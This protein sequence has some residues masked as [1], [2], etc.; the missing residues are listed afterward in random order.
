[1]NNKRTH[2]IVAICLGLGLLTSLPAR[3]AAA[4]Q[5]LVKTDK[6][7]L[8]TDGRIGG[9]A[10]FAVGDAYPKSTALNTPYGGGVGTNDATSIDNTPPDTPLPQAKLRS[11]RIRSGFLSNIFAFGAR[12]QISDMK[13]TSY[14]QFWSDIES[15]GSRKYVP[16]PVDVRQ[17]FLKLEGRWGSLA[18]G[19]MGT[20]FSRGAAEIDFLYGH[21]YGVGFPTNLTSNGT[22]A[23]HVG[24]GVLGPGFA[25]GFVYVTPDLAGLHLN[26]GMFDPVVIVGSWERTEWPRGEAELTFDQKFGSNGKV[27]AFVNGAY[28]TVYRPAEP[29]STHTAA[30][31]AGYGARV[32]VGPVHL[33]VAGHYGQG[34]GLYYALEASEASADTSL[35]HRLR[36]SDGYYAQLQIALPKVDL[37]A[38]AGI[39]RVF[40]LNAETRT[41]GGMAQSLPADGTPDPN[42]GNRQSLIKYQLGLSAAVVYHVSE[43]LHF[44]FDYFRA[45]FAWQ[46]GEKQAVNFFNSGLTATW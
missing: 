10:S 34:L 30:Y 28:Q 45:S 14:I 3:R 15:E 8:F 11:L 40:P 9:F 18:V 12:T 32:E 5:T 24:T 19:R 23:G 44:D 31:G 7:E 2:G 29:D 20:L 33:G 21:G 36:K 42:T 43:N 6:W 13:L 38:G 46:F 16:A 37:N 1:V 17:G 4:E 41:I 39:S 22:T 26:V 25:A 35:A 27:H